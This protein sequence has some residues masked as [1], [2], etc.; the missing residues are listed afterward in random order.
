MRQVIVRGQ[1]VAVADRGDRAPLLLVHGFPLD[2]DVWHP[3]IEAFAA[4]RRVVAPDLVGFGESAAIERSSL[5]D[6]ADDLA[7]LLDALRIERA[8]V[9]G[10]SMGGYVALAL[11]RRHAARVAGLGLVCTR[12][13]ADT[14]AGRAGRYQM[15][16]AV[17]DHGVG[18]VAEALLP[19]LLAPDAAPDVVERVR[20]MMYRQST[21]GV[22][23]ALH[24]MAARPSTT[25]QL[26]AIQVPTLVVTGAADGLIPGEE[27]ALMAGSVPGARLVVLP[28]AGHLANL[29][30]PGAF[31]A[32]LR[33][34]LDVVDRR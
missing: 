27:A 30:A 22:I 2:H 19:R 21:V 26:A 15:A 33:E 32:A 16:I 14:E 11:W 29:E 12:A 25:A 18:V 17:A 34:F 10:L 7:A 13:G 6:H 28:G 24:A 3:Q 8:V 9:V 31:N 20:A 4:S 1:T 23:S 5:D